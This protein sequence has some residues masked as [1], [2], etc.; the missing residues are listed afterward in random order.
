MN[1]FL[2]YPSERLMSFLYFYV[3]ANKTEIYLHILYRVDVKL[4]F[5]PIELGLF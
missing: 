1:M 5:V 2:R 3:N 4:T